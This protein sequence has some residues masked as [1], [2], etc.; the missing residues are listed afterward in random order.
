MCSDK[1]K[2]ISMLNMEQKYSTPSRISPS[3]NRSEGWGC[4]RSL[5]IKAKCE[6]TR[7]PTFRRRT[8]TGS[9]K[10]CQPVALRWGRLLLQ[11]LD[12]CGSA[13]ILTWCLYTSS[14]VWIMGLVFFFFWKFFDFRTY[15]TFSDWTTTL[16]VFILLMFK[17][18]Q[19]NSAPSGSGRVWEWHSC[20][21]QGNT[22]RTTAIDGLIFH[23][24]SLSLFIIIRRTEEVEEEEQ[25]SPF[26]L[27]MN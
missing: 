5:Q 18:W 26:F 14:S 23:A 20:S 6:P 15:G 8:R 19:S 24:L 22:A 4:E 27:F 12:F 7:S 1:K 13:L 25:E 2:Y 10:S 9:E 3:A 11:L 21:T 17:A 16:P